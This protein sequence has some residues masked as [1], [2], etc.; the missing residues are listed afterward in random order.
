M[1]TRLAGGIALILVVIT[2]LLMA[3]FRT[4][5]TLD[6]R[7]ALYARRAAQESAIAEGEK[8][9]RQLEA[10][11]TQTEQLAADGDGTAKSVLDTLRRQGVV[12]TPPKR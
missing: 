9:R 8:L 1:S 4:V 3:V 11:A 7:D 10:I 2:L 5:E 12:F 6:Y